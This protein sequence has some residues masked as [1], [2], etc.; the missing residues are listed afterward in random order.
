MILQTGTL[1]TTYRIEA[2]A[3]GSEGC[4]WWIVYIGPDIAADHDRAEAE[5]ERLRNEHQGTFYRMV[6][7]HEHIERNGRGK[8]YL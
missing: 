6:M 3:D 1:R 4:D 8:V 7:V 5:Y 2:S